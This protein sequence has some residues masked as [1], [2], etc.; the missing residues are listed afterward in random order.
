[1]ESV[2]AYSKRLIVCILVFDTTKCCL[3]YVRDCWTAGTRLRR[4]HLLV[5]LFAAMCF[6]T[7]LNIDYSVDQVVATC[8]AKRCV[9]GVWRLQ[10]ALACCRQ[11]RLISMHAEA[12]HYQICFWT[13]TC[14]YWKYSIESSPRG[15]ERRKCCAD[16][17]YTR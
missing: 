11:L 7:H 5:S 1:M 4:S 6:A 16:V 9:C 15:G 14:L 10:S 12:R 8:L 13:I 3:G 17:Q 2:I